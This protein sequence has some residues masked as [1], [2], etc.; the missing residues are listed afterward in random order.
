MKGFADLENF[1]PAKANTAYR[2]ASISKSFTATAIMQLVDQGK[3]DLDIYIT[4]LTFTSSVFNS[5]K[6][7]M[8]YYSTIS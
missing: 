3:I 8:K 4:V 2:S 5:S 7:N 6:S 1:V